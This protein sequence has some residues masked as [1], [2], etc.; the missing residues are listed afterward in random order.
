MPVMK[1]LS[2]EAR[3]KAADA[4]SSAVPSRPMGIILRKI[5]AC[6]L[7]RPFRADIN[8]GRLGRPRT[9]HVCPN[10]TAGQLCG[11]ATDKEA[12]A[13]FVAE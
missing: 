4:S 6:A 8:H 3:N 11:P 5:F 7:W 9:D 1:L 10:A 12:S 2:S 13:A